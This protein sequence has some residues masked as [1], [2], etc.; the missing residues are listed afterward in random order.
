M[1]RTQ[2]LLLAASAL[3]FT[4]VPA[5][6]QAQPAADP[7]FETFAPQGAPI[8]HTIDYSIWD[9][10]MK[11]LVISMG[12]S[13]RE[14]A[15]SPPQSF[16]TRRQY[17]HTSRYRLEGSRIM[18]SFLDADIRAS[19]TEYR[20]DLESVADQVDIQSL[21]RNE[22]LAYWINLHNVAMIEQIADAWPVRQPRDIK[23][24]GVPLDEARFI[25]V[26]GIAMSPR[27]I[28]EKI[29]FANWS[30]PK[31]MYGFWRGEIG[32]PSI[33]R[34]AFNADNVARLLDRGARDFVNSLRGTQKTGSTLQVSELY[35]EAAPFFFDN[36]EAD[37]RA[38]IALYADEDTATLLAGTSRLEA[39][40]S[41]P[42]IAD[43]AGG[44][45]EPSYQNI[46]SADGTQAS[47]RIP[48]SMQRLLAQREEKFQR[49]IREGRTG[50]VTFSNI[51][52]PG[53][54]EGDGEVE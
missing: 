31:V 8:D 39:S 9:E 23:I 11:N 51:D 17:G 44:V 49:I 53:D 5:T 15:G 37:L 50:T 26:E 38:H 25:T 1:P 48:Q 54:P 28:R 35:Q 7:Q 6:A 36:F 21:S 41:E 16:G 42:D 32:G 24:G 14:T 47:F 45:R 18:F 13:L 19:F 3:A 33:Q 22:Q 34:E 40:V 27:D 10:A 52:L 12:P 4:A 2:A 20:R 43:L 30:D 46:Q 29:V